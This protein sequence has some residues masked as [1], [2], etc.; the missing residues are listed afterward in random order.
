MAAME[1]RKDGIYDA[2]GRWLAPLEG[3]ETLPPV[4]V[5]LCSHGVLCSACAK[6]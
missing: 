1:A 4:P 5:K 6:S 2:A 3:N